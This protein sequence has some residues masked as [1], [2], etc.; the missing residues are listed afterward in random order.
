M[1]VRTVYGPV[2][3][4]RLGRSLGIDP[5]PL[6]TC[7]WNCIYCQL[8]RS[9]PLTSERRAYI[10]TDHIL[11][12]VR[13]ALTRHGPRDVDWITF[14]GSGEPLLHSGIGDLVRGVRSITDIPLAVIT[15][16][17][18]L[19]Q[20]EVREAILPV[21]AVLP[22]LDAGSEALFRRIDRPHPGSTFEKHIRGIET[23][24]REFA[25][26]LFVE[27]MLLAGVNDGRV[28]LED[29]AKVLARIAPDEIHLVVPNRPAVEPWVRG[30]DRD[31]I[32]RA[33]E[34]LAR[35]GRVRSSHLRGRVFNRI[36][37]APEVEEL[38]EIIQRHPMTDT[39]VRETVERWA[40]ERSAE[41][42][43]H[44][45]S[46]STVRTVVRD[47]QTYWVSS[48]AHFPEEGPIDTERKD[49]AFGKRRKG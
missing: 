21:Q 8:G 13:E 48:S 19:Y 3:S 38:T 29:M 9:R 41:V 6:K 42:L 44:L 46:S 11:Q 24:R 30:T 45:R 22:T 2:P 49:R 25:G 17:S 28:A 20:P 26:L 32:R 37:R 15:N 5:I 10:P 47:R 27:V 4:R 31:G 12:E 14:V 36:S 40:P 16:G 1:A 35:A 34:I 43:E 18:L 39:Q 7:N 23:F 33:E